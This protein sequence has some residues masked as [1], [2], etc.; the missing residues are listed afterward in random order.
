MAQKICTACL[1][2]ALVVTPVLWG[3][4]LD[5]ALEA[6]KGDDILG[7]AFV[8]PMG[9]I[10][11]LTVVTAEMIFF[12]TLRGILAPRVYPLRKRLLCA[13]AFLGNILAVTWAIGH[14]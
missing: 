3:I 1:I 14:I 11:L 4:D 8:A 7:T 12:L 13:S 6:A 9:F 10:L 5:R 2:V